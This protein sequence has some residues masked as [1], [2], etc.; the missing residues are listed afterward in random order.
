MGS[1]RNSYHHGDLR[2]ALVEAGLTATRFRGPAGLGL[3]EVTRRVGVSPNAAYRHFGDRQALLTAV[4][5]E[6]QDKMADTMRSRMPA[7]V[8][9]KT[10]EKARRLRGVGLGYIAFATAEPGWF[11]TAF[12]GSAA[13]RDSMPDQDRTPPPFTLLVDALDAMVESGELSTERREGAEWACWSTVHGFAE[14]VVHGPLR[15]LEAETVS[16]WAE[17]VVDDI[18]S[19]IT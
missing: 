14:L 17:R 4:A 6:I 16:R 5:R 2:H 18:I 12:F 8:S 13:E 15:Q 1:R 11:E 7:S 10:A 19:G 9:G 3:R